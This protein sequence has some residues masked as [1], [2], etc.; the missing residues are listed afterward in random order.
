MSSRG[1]G[2]GGGERLSYSKSSSSATI[3]N[4]VSVKSS[5]LNRKG[6]ILPHESAAVPLYSIH[7]IFQI[8]MIS[9][10]EKDLRIGY[11]FYFQTK[12]F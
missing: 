3:M 7:K 6:N 2:E 9:S 10:N 12:V 1:D 11:F 8:R 4:I 5:K